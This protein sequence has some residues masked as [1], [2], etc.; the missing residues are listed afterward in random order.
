MPPLHTA[1]PPTPLFTAVFLP[2]SACLLPG[3]WAIL[4]HLAPLYKTRPASFLGVSCCLPWFFILHFCLPVHGSS[5]FRRKPLSVM[6]LTHLPRWHMASPGADY[7]APALL[8]WPLTDFTFSPLPA[9][10][11]RF[12]AAFCSAPTFYNVSSCFAGF[13]PCRSTATRTNYALPFCAARFTLLRPFLAHACA[14]HASACLL[15]HC[16]LLPATLSA[17]F[18][19]LCLLTLCL[20]AFLLYH[21]AFAV[22]Q[23]SYSTWF[24]STG[25]GMKGRR[26]PS[27]WW[28]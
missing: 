16:I 14:L 17:G 7:T 3:F 5:Y 15:S 11:H 23:F 26:L 21:S 10:S 2:S 20:P 28:T 19:F 9:F 18:A 25:H 1:L 27:A 12:A 4:P 24:I 13:L 6:L 22:Q 8:T